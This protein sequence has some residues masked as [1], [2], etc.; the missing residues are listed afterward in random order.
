MTGG[1]ASASIL[2]SASPSTKPT[3]STTPAT[4][5]PAPT[6]AST[7]V[8]ATEAPPGAIVIDTG[9]NPVPHFIPDE[10]SVKAGKAIFF[11]TNM[12]GRQAP[13]N[14]A[15][16]PALHEVLVRSRAVL[17]LRSVV[18]TVED[19]PAGD[20]VFWCEVQGHD[21]PEMVGSLTVTP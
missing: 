1:A 2:A 21:A 13:H 14:M 15:I 8:E 6:L 9:E 4:P 19:L 10:L 20:Y 3:A 16:G 5:T 7:T 17:N 11:I 18:F 12:V